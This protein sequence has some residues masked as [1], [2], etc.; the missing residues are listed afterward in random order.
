MDGGGTKLK[1]LDALSMEKAMVAHEVACEGINVN[2][3]ENVIF[4]QSVNE[5][6]DAIKLLV[7]DIDKRNSMGLAARKLIEEQYAYKMV[8]KKLSS[9]YRQCLERAPPKTNQ[10]R[11]E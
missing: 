2:N 6:V 11:E 8:G 3:G 7:D 1:V 9:L 4:A 10:T 5:Y